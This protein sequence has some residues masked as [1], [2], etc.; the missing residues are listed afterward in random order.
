MVRVKVT[1]S[2]SAL[3]RSA[4]NAYANGTTWFPR[5]WYVTHV[6]EPPTK[7]NL[8]RVKG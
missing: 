2:V 7:K 3:P 6:F 1:V 5:L 8:V 4:S